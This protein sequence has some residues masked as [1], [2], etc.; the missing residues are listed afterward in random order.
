MFL[1]M[2]LTVY[3]VVL[4]Q[5]TVINVHMDM[6]FLLVFVYHAILTIVLI[7]RKQT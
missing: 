2:T 3:D 4:I 1:A 6:E 5:V 7:V